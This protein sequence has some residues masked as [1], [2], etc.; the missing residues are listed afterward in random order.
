MAADP[1][2]LTAQRLRLRLLAQPPAFATA[3]RLNQSRQQTL[4]RALPRVARA[5]AA[6][7]SVLQRVQL[8]HRAPIVTRER[9]LVRQPLL[10]HRAEQGTTQ[11]REHRF[12]PFAIT[13]TMARQAQGLQVAP[14]VPMT[15]RHRS[16]TRQVTHFAPC[17][18]VDTRGQE[19]RV[20]KALRHALT[21]TSKALEVIAT[22][23]QLTSTTR[24]RLLE[25]V[26]ILVTPYAGL[27]RQ[28]PLVAGV[29]R[30]LAPTQLTGLHA[31]AKE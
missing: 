2:A 21:V 19:A 5:L 28:A 22:S 4:G 14:S 18:R 31:Q 9:T 8:P 29:L 16:G 30:H 13:G 12:A 20:C 11:V 1:A 6:R 15:E 27:V 26:I 17:V 7:M 25:G 10:A 23:A 3:E 24:P